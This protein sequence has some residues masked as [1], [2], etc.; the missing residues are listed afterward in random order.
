MA[1]GSCVV[2][3]V[4][5]RCTS[6]LGFAFWTVIGVEAFL[7]FLAVKLCLRNYRYLSCYR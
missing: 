7:I 2:G 3:V 1:E 6:M 5:A 4:V